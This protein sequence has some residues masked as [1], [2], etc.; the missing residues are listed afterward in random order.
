MLHEYE[1]I[2][3]K[4]YSPEISESTIHTILNSSNI[5]QVIPYYKWNLINADLDDNKFVDCAL[6]AGI[7]YIVTNDKHFNVLKNIDFP[8][9]KVV[10]IETFREIMSK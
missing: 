7:D 5:E 4:L 8:E 10:D 1:E 2:L 6:N 9:I 3:S